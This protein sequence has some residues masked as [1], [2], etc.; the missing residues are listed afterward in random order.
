MQSIAARARR[1][2][3]QLDKY[4]QQYVAL[5]EECTHP[6]VTEKY[7]SSTGNYDPSNDGYWIDYYCPDCDKK[8]TEFQ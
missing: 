6:N 8:W 1:I 3:K 2:K 7:G 4:H 5:Q